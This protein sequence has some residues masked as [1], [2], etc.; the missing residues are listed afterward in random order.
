[1]DVLQLTQDTLDDLLGSAGVRSYWGQR[2]EIDSGAKTDEYIVYSQDDDPITESAD[3]ETLARTASI[4]IRYYIDQT[5]R[6]TYNGRVAYTERVN[7]ILIAMT[8]AGFLCPSGW[9]E[10]GDI[11]DVGFTVFLAVFDYARVEDS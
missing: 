7:S 4:A 2:G 11:D 1:M 5:V 8:N 10:I 6:K 3:G 9:M